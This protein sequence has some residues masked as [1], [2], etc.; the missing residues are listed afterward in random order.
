MMPYDL[1]PQIVKLML[2]VAEWMLLM[3]QIF[4]TILVLRRYCHLK[5]TLCG[6][7]LTVV[8]VLPTVLHGVEYLSD[9]QG[10]TVPEILQGPL[11]LPW[12]LHI[13][14]VM[15]VLSLT[16]LLCYWVYRLQR[17]K[18]TP[19]SIK[20][21]MDNLPVGLCFAGTDGLPI[22][23]NRAMHAISAELTGETV[24]SSHLLWE[25]ISAVMEDGVLTMAN[26]SHWKID[27]TVA[28]VDGEQ[29]EQITAS[30]ITQLHALRKEYERQVRL[31]RAMNLR[32]RQ[33]SH[34]V[35]EVTTAREI[36]RTKEYVHDEMG[37]VLLAT[38]R[39]LAGAGDRES[40]DKLLEY[41]RRTVYFLGRADQQIADKQM[42][43]D[44]LCR[45]AAELG[46][47]LVVEGE[48][49]DDNSTVMELVYVAAR[50]SLTNTVRH[51]GGDLLT[52]SVGREGENY[53]ITCRDN[54]SAP[55]G[56]VREGGGLSAIRTR[57]HLA[58]GIMRVIT[59]DGFRLELVVPAERGEEL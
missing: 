19:A 2:Q 58:G 9:I 29:V 5:Y 23:V 43:M 59:D 56:E 18:I 3:G 12:V 47:T 16:L 50:E 8:N 42:D 33:Y 57:T 39:Y 15:G 54:G 49:P 36:L 27:R 48:L 17:E 6:A 53:I 20:E 13:G 52:V 22:L 40:V 45:T 44:R 34:E 26:G 7:A 51:A 46:V 21:G 25:A 37:K 10:R 11:G 31:L 35:V 41:W 30:D 1:I 55:V 28:E 24:Q 14:F 32:L 4:L 38:N